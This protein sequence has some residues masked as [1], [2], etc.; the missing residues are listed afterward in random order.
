MR[1]DAIRNRAKILDAARVEIAAQGPEVGMDAIA[2]AAGVAVGTLYRHFPTKVDLV[3]AVLE[4]YVEQVTAE[5]AAALDAVHAGAR[6]P[7]SALIGFLIEVIRISAV[8]KA[9]KGAASTLGAED[10][11]DESRAASAVAELIRLGIATGE[12][13]A[14]LTVADIYL[15][16]ASAPLNGPEAVRDRWMQ[17]VL[18]CLTADAAVIRL[19]GMPQRPGEP[20]R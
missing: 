14:D 3:A 16:F 2:A 5:A 18:P 8:N 17:L 6:T 11:L 19:A 12:V 13:R 10:R 7:L 4:E 9:A 1:A 15:V 20:G